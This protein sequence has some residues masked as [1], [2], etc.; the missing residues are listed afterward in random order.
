LDP[1]KSRPAPTTDMSL[2][3][4]EDRNPYLTVALFSYHRAQGTDDEE[5]AEKL[6]FDSVEEMRE[7]LQ[8]WELPGWLVGKASST[9]PTKDNRGRRPGQGAGER[10]E[11][12][13]AK[14]AIPLFREMLDVLHEAI[15]ELEHRKEYF[16]DGRLVV[17]THVQGHAYDGGELVEFKGA[18]P[19]GGEQSPPEPLTSLIAICVLAGLPLEPLLNTLN[20]EPRDVDLDQLDRSIEGKRRKKGHTPGLKSKACGAVDSRG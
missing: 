18:F 17:E 8:E 1:A 11:L 15:E 16:Q 12:P 3:E 13:P 19:G 10:V 14:E 6:R 7:Q 4:P 5:I 9:T 20:R 2:S